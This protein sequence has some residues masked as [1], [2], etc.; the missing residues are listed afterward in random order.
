MHRTCALDGTQDA[1]NRA[2]NNRARH[3]KNVRLLRA[4]LYKRIKHLGGARKMF[5]E[6]DSDDSGTLDI[7]ELTAGM[8]KMG[9]TCL[10]DEVTSVMSAIDTDSNGQISYEEL[11]SFMF[12]NMPVDDPQAPGKEQALAAVQEEITKYS[13][14][15][16]AKLKFR[17]GLHKPGG[18]SIDELDQRLRAQFR[19][20]LTPED[21]SSVLRHFDVTKTGRLDLDALCSGISGESWKRAV[22]CRVA[23]QLEQAG[24]SGNWSSLSPPQREERKEVRRDLAR[25]ALAESRSNTVLPPNRRGS[26]CAAGAVGAEAEEGLEAQHAGALRR[27]ALQRVVVERGVLEL[28]E[29]LVAAQAVPSQQLPAKALRREATAAGLLSQAQFGM[30]LREVDPERTGAVTA[31]ALRAFLGSDPSGPAAA[32]LGSSADARGRER[33]RVREGLRRRVE[34]RH[35]Q[36]QT[37]QREGL[38]EAQFHT[39]YQRDGHGCRVDRPGAMNTL[40]RQWVRSGAAPGRPG[41]PG[42]VASRL[43]PAASRLRLVASLKGLAR[44]RST[45]GAIKAA[46]TV[47]REQQGLACTPLATLVAC[48]ALSQRQQQ[49]QQRR[50]RRGGD[51]ARARSA[52]GLLPAQVA[53]HTTPARAPE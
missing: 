42:P 35:W 18:L 4:K 39:R 46:T 25:R 50:R 27:R 24:L 51:R 1:H 2:R 28:A 9:L 29:R 38:T 43:D 10:S 21:L 6:L 23:Q 40:Q 14:G 11:S 32:L 5:D 47:V 19:L 34:Q 48:D 26:H 49:Q 37:M 31:A 8:R 15:G 12:D 22:D 45:A 3:L 41:A 44:A 16:L 33:G 17:S 52:L 7:G 13:H 20:E 36:A 53:W 30:L